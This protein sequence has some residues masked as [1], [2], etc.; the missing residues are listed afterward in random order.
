MK[1]V[2]VDAAG[3]LRCWNCGN[4]GFKSKRTLRSKVIVGVG[5]LATKKKLKCETCG[6]YNDTGS[7]KPF[8]GPASGKW[9]RRW[10]KEEAAK[11]RAARKSEQSAAEAAA[12]AVVA[13]VAAEASRVE[14]E[15]WEMVAAEQPEPAA[16]PPPAETST[17]GIP[18]PP[19][20]PAGWATDPTGR[21]QMRWW[22][23]DFWTQHVADQGQVGTDPYTSVADNG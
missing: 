10:K 19:V 21:H 1:D 12:T 22:D 8:D 17:V 3:E 9:R 2:R 23:G 16:H 20:I 11:S 4:K 6:E 13:Q 15:E 7:A 18:A 14:R 5:A